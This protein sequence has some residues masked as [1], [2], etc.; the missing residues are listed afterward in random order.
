MLTSPGNSSASSRHQHR[1]V[2]LANSHLIMKTPMCGVV[3]EEGAVDVVG[4]GVE[5]VMADMET[6]KVGTTKVGTIKVDTIKAGT[7]KM[8]GTMII[9]ADTTK[10]VGTMIIKV[11]MAVDMATTKA[12]KETTKKMVDITEDGVVC[13][14]EAIGVTAGDMSVAGVAVPQVGGDM[15]VEGDMTK[16]LL[17][18]ATEV[19]GD[20][21]AEG[22]MTKP[23]LEGDTKAE[24]DMTKLLLGGGDTRAEG[25]M[26]G[27]VEEWLVGEGTEQRQNFHGLLVL[28]KCMLYNIRGKVSYP[29]IFCWKLS[30]VWVLVVS[31]E[32]DVWL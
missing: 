2:N 14:E 21:K 17:E 22:D 32:R 3:A 7:T 9:K 6:T 23:L 18:G 29:R 26:E 20:M 16:L 10:M 5:E 1:C 31:P 19:E 15:K 27:L 11:G 24:G 25:G 4:V 12:D 13:V 30:F 8:V 28:F